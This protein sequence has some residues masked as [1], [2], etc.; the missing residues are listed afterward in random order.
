MISLPIEVHKQWVGTACIVPNFELKDAV[1]F[2]R[3]L[4]TTSG[5]IAKVLDENDYDL[6]VA[7]KDLKQYS[8][9]NKCPDA[10]NSEKPFYDS[11]FLSI[12]KQR[13]KLIQS[14]FVPVIAE[15]I[16]PE[17]TYYFLQASDGQFVFL[18][19]LDTKIMK[20]EF[21]AY[22]K[23]PP[24]LSAFVIAFQEST[25][26]EVILNLNPGFAEKMQIS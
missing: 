17:V 8:L 6:R 25:I 18:H 10:Y 19:P 22:E 14:E 1:L 20:H 24:K 15:I 2:S 12:K 7:E 9:D 16:Q 13:D 5:R 4:I 23:F 3:V 11:C 21:H 26:D